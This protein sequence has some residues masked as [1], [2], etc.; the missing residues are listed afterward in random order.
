V[1]GL[2]MMAD[3]LTGQTGAYYRYPTSVPGTST[4]QVD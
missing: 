1:S 3:G 2:G 4:L